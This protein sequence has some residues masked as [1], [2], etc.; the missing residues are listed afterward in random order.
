MGK[1]FIHQSVH[2]LE[3]LKFEGLDVKETGHWPD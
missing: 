2:V 1:N 3:T